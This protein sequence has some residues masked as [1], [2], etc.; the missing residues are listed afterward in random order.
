MPTAAQWCV[1]VNAARKR[2]SAWNNDGQWS[3]GAW[4]SKVGEQAPTVKDVYR[5]TFLFV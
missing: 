3:G 5:N 4:K 1:N 2:V